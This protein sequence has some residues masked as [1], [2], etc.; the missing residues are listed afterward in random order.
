[1][2]N[3]EQV[4]EMI[5]RMKKE[6]VE[7]KRKKHQESFTI[8][9]NSVLQDTRMSFAARGLYAFIKSLPEDWT[10]YESWLVTQ[11][12]QGKD[13][14]RTILKELEKFGFINRYSYR[15]KGQFVKHEMIFSV[16]PIPE[17]EMIDYIKIHDDGSFEPIYRIKD[18]NIVEPD[19][20]NPNMGGVIENSIFQPDS[21]N[22][23]MDKPNMENPPLQNK[24]NN[25]TNIYTNQSVS[26]E[27]LQENEQKKNQS[28]EN[29]RL[30]DKEI[31]NLI[32][33]PI[34][35]LKKAYPNDTKLIEEL[36]LNIIDMF[37][38]DYIIIEGQKK[39]QN[40]IRLA[41]MKLTY[42]HLEEI[43]Q[44]FK[45]ISSSI[46]ITNSKAYIQSMIYNTALESD[47]SITNSVYYNFKLL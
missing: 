12:P 29:D 38:N 8:L 19:S 33:E 18:R 7:V 14:L 9:D 31:D 21:E 15:Y 42:F 43:L 13:A 39:P 36:K 17:D 40:L 26:Q 22:P 24:H 3:K 4:L 16:Y 23:N 28:I 46:K 32:N 44:K 5:Q 25:K 45:D 20:E 2:K 6:K 27:D 35:E 34:E 41:I 47:L 37:F 11:S 1:M 30:I 10:L